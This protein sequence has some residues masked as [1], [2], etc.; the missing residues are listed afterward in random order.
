MVSSLK[1]FWDKELEKQYSICF[2]SREK[3]SKL[4]NSDRAPCLWRT[5]NVFLK[6]HD[7]KY[8]RWNY[9]LKG[10]IR[11]QLFS[12]IIFNVYLIIKHSKHYYKYI[13]YSFSLIL[14][15]KFDN[16]SSF[17]WHCKSKNYS[18]ITIKHLATYFYIGHNK[19]QQNKWSNNMR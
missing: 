6:K 15:A 19:N 9:I 13:E 17:C 2:S 5:E 12:S 10:L 3:S 8:L 11:K 1:Y 14:N 18:I 4:S 7:F 16:N